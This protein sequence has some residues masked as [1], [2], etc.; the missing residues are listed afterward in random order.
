MN[1]YF[2]SSA[3][4]EQIDFP[5]SKVSKDPADLRFADGIYDALADLPVCS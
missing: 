1:I 2:H 5:G 3:R 4:K